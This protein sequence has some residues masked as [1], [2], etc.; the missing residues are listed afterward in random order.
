ME[1]ALG[2]KRRITL[3]DGKSLD[4]TIPPGHQS[5]QVLRLRAQGHPGRGGASAGDALIEVATMAEALAKL[6]E[7]IECAPFTMDELEALGFTLK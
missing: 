6:V 4:V 2:T 1:A 7:V 5:G 3:P